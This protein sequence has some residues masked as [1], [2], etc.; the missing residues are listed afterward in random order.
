MIFAVKPNLTKTNEKENFAQFV[1]EPL[2]GG[3]GMTLGHSLRRVLLT[4]LEGAA[5]TR[6]KIDNVKHEFSTLTGVKEDIIDLV[7]NIKKIKVFLEGK[8]E[9][10]MVLEKKGPGE[11]KAGDIVCPQGVRILN[12]EEY[13]TTLADKK[14]NLKIEFLVKKGKGYI[15]ADVQEV[16][17]IGVIPIDSIFT[18]VL[19]VD[20]KVVDTRVGG[21]TDFNKLT[22]DITTNGGIEPQVALNRAAEILKAYYAFIVDPE[23]AEEEAKPVNT[24]GVSEKK[25]DIL[26]EELNL[27]MRVVNSLTAANIKT[28]SQLTEKSE[29]EISKVKNLGSKSVKQIKAKLTEM[30]Y[31]L[32]TE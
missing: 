29:K 24:E 25:E 4:S 22:L 2:P 20:Y 30:G 31:S 23:S 8:D 13:V 9:A 7:L 11:V 28:I 21:E 5:I 19:D 18:P 12:P 1:I 3:F 26:I 32:K 14:T 10:T 15:P 27:P 17:E 6:I 16:A